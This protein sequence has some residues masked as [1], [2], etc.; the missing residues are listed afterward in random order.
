M[1]LHERYAKQRFSR[2]I[3][4]G[5]HPRAFTFANSLTQQWYELLIIQWEKKQ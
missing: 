2:C 1:T 4:W 5:I 3:A